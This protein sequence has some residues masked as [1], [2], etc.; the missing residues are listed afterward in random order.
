MTEQTNTTKARI[1]TSRGEVNIKRRGWGRRFL[2]FLGP[3]YLV[4]VGYMDPGNWAT[5]I[6]A[7]ARFG[8]SL[9]WVIL[10]SNMMAILLQ[11]LS[12][13][14]GIVT[15]LDLA[16]GCRREY[17]RPVTFVLWVFAEIAIAACDLAEALGTIIGLN[18][19][20][21][22]PML[23]GCAVTALDTFLLLAL[24]R[25]G[26]RK[27][28]AFIIMM[29]CTVGGCFLIEVFLS[30]PDWG[31][32]AGG[33]I[34]RMDPSAVYIVIGIIGATVM[35]HNLY[36]HS[37]LVQSRAVSNTITG[38][39]EAS[40][41]NM[42]D[43][44]VALNGAFF[45]N[46]AILI[47]AAATFHARGI[48]VTEIKQAHMMLGNILG[49]TVA[50]IAFAIALVA[51]GQSST[52]TG[53]I[54][55]QIV[56]EGFLNLRVRPWLRRLITRSIALIPAVVAIAL[57]GESGTYRLL[58]LSQVVLSLQLP[59]AVIPLIHFTSDRRKMGSFASPRWVRMLAWT[60]AVTIVALNLKLVHATLSE[61]MGSAPLW[62]WVILA[63]TLGLG[64][65]G[66]VYITL[67]PF[68][69]R[70]QEWES[71]ID[72]LS[73]SVAEQI[74]PVAIQEIGVALEH[75]KGDAA[76]VS[77]A[78]TMAKS[79]KAR[80]TLIHVVDTPG[81]LVYGEESTSRH[82]EEDKVYLEQVAREIEERELPVEIILRNGKPVDELVRVSGELGFDLLIMGSHGH[83]GLGD[84]IHGATV[85]SVRH[86]VECA[87]MVVRTK[88]TER[89]QREANGAATAT[90][91]K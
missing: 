48:E 19:L 50:P 54:A 70:G 12:A 59:F 56:M 62:A 87:V 74:R 44:V 83:R 60:I 46:A 14:L 24:Q 25:F 17:P 58:I 68:F 78:V 2:A 51:A 40:R 1:E 37:S 80:L 47:M 53:T 82:G 43:S 18:L 52:I 16:Q 42:L 91:P 28:E 84:L 81:A 55:G 9:L 49:H 8:Y 32:I 90:R 61:W 67:R 57:W 85:D 21:G 63:P 11:T 41:F 7:G 39:R 15:G 45:V 88:G 26:V 31:G 33:F 71:G 35:P 73:R 36:L 20:F 38:K 10:M 77:A 23:W 86:A 79:H 76:I 27:I 4:S 89:A 65:A 34:P 64:L 69:G 29:V 6:E 75:A 13:R 66:L 30:R 72:T 3:A 22:L 5:D